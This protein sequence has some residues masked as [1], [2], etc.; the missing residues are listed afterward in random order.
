MQRGKSI[1]SAR[2]AGTPVSSIPEKR[3]AHRITARP[4]PVNAGENRNARLDNFTRIK[5]REELKC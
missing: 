4:F 1:T 2:F 5:R 3:M